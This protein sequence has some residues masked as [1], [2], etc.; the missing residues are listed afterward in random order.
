V[1]K[2]LKPGSRIDLTVRVEAYDVAIQ[3]GPAKHRLSAAET[4]LGKALNDRLFGS[5]VS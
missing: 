1:Q 4:G 3:T 5:A 2:D